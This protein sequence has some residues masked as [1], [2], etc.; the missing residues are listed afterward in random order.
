MMQVCKKI[1]CVKSSNNGLAPERKGC[2]ISLPS[3]LCRAPGLPS[4]RPSIRGSL[5]GGRVILRFVAR[6]NSQRYK[7]SADPAQ[8]IV[9]FATG[10]RSLLIR[11]RMV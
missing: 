8:P 3:M 2:V 9:I 5:A 6:G 1:S 7:L 10:K 4:L 11:G